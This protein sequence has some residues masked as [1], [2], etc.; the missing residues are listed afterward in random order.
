MYFHENASQFEFKP[1]VVSPLI[2]LR[3]VLLKYGIIR[4]SFACILLINSLEVFYR[5]VGFVLSVVSWAQIIR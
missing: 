4:G 5:Q 1:F 2:L 3:R